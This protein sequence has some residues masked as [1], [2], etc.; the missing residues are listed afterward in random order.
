[1]LIEKMHFPWRLRTWDS[2]TR[3]SFSG[4][5]VLSTDRSFLLAIV[6]PS[7][8]LGPSFRFSAHTLHLPLSRG[9]R[10]LNLCA[11]LSA[12]VFVCILSKYVWTGK[13]NQMKLKVKKKI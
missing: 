6:P 9:N 3:E 10:L 2:G 5:V 12:F 13:K 4:P 11:S 8:F 1:M 7:L